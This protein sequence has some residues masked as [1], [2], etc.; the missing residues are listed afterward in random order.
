MR[1]AAVLL[2]L[3]GLW[4]APLAAQLPIRGQVLA[5]ENEQPL[6]GAEIYALRS[7]RGAATDRHGRFVL[8]L[9]VVPDTL[10]AHFIGRAP[11]TAVV[12]D[13]AAAAVV[14]HLQSTAVALPGVTVQAEP[15]RRSDDAAQGATWSLPREAIATVPGAVESDV[16]RGLAL[17]P[18]VAYSTP[19]SAQP[20]VRGMDPGA[21]SYRLDGFTVINPFHIGRIFS[22]LMPQA[23]QGAKLAAAPFDLEYGDATS[24]VIDAPLRE[25]G[26]EIQGGAQASF[27]SVAAWLGGPANSHRWFLAWRHGF[28]EHVG[29]PLHEVPYHFNDVYG[30]FAIAAP[31]GP[32][33]LTT[34]WS[35][36]GVHQRSS[37]QGV[38]WS[39]ALIG[40]RAPLPIGR[41]GRVELWGEL[42]GFREDVVQ[43][44]IRGVDTDVR[45]RFTT[46]AVGACFQW[47]AAQTAAGLSLE[48]RRRHMTNDIRGGPQS[49]PSVDAASTFAAATASVERHTGRFTAR[50][51][52]RLDAARGI[53]AWQPRLHLGLD[54]GHEWSLGFALGRTAR[55]Y[56]V[57][58]EAVPGVEEILSIY[59]LWR[60]AGQ[61]GTPLSVADHGIVELKR[62]TASVSLRMSAFA[63]RLRGVGEVRG[64]LLQASDSAF[65]RFGR[66]RVAG[67]DAELRR[68]GTRANI[69]LGYVLSWSRR[70]WDST[71][72]T[73]IPWRYDRRHQAR[74]FYSLLAGRGWRFHFVGEIG[75]G[76]P[77]TPALGTITV[78]S[79]GA[80]GTLRRGGFFG[81]TRLI[82]GPENSAR[83]GWTG[84]V[85]VGFEKEIGGPGRSVGRLGISVL[86]VAFMPI[87]PGVPDVD[88]DPKTGVERVIYQPQ[89]FL[90]PVP[91]LTFRLEF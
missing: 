10:I 70:T 50:G 43:L 30:R 90:P 11:D 86:N 35:N 13:S 46:S 48:L 57:I 29:G 77:I 62:T 75:S 60:P 78:G 45:N 18:A 73:E 19:L 16:F 69:G 7:R 12:S 1:S 17:S 44:P 66:G 41:S 56:H 53:H 83:G 51:G 49:A 26:S 5:A 32:I 25:G 82:M 24:A 34:F 14:F 40:A 4:R 59:D 3:L 20:L 85:D 47:T 6:A 76:D 39:N 37:G 22:A 58:N 65:F 8:W 23:V 87:A 67:I 64:S 79:M 38:G 71:N 52:V 21:V 2:A 84:H 63:S 68:P 28:L 54:L 9:R 36:D 42:S 74:V 27:V 55:L 88:F 33:H 81:N 80:D 89:I 61:D 15:F 91:T 72:A 31:W